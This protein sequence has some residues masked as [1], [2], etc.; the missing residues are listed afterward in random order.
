MNLSVIERMAADGDMSADAFQYLLRCHGECEWLDYKEILMLEHDKQLCDFAKDIV[1]IKNTGGGYVLVG[2]RDKTWEPVG[3]TSPLPFDTKMI[4][5]QIRKATGLDLDVDIVHHKTQLT[6]STGLF[7]LILIRSSRKRRRRRSPSLI[8]KDFCVNKDFGLRRGDIYVRRGD[9]TI[10]IST[11]KELE[12]LLDQLEENA[13]Q[14]ALSLVGRG[15]PFAVHNGTYLL[16]EKGFEQFI[17]R[18]TLRSGLLDA[19][20]KDPRI[21]I[22]NV[23]GPGGAGK[24]ALVNW[25]VYEFFQNRQFEAI[26]QLTAKDTVLTTQGIEKYGRTLYSLEN[27]LDHV[28]M[29]FDETLPS[30]L[31]EKKRIV[32]EY[33]SA[34][35][36]LLV[37]DNMETVQDGRILNFVQSLPPE[38]KAKVLMTSRQKT[39]GWELPFPVNELNVKEVQDFVTIRSSEMGISFPNDLDTSEK[40]WNATGGLPLAI[41]WVLGRYKTKPSLEEITIGVKTKDSPVLEFSFRNI[42]KVLSP[43]AKALLAII[44][45]FD[46]PPTVQSICI[47]TQFP[48]EKVEKAL[49]E[50]DEVTLVNK[51]TSAVDGRVTFVA[52]P[53][54]LAFARNQLAEMDDFEVQCRQRFQKYSEQI[55]LQ[56]SEIFRFRSRFQQFGLETDNEKKAAILCQRGESEMFIGNVNNAD[57][58]F[59]QA[60][61]TAPQSSYVYAMSA[62]YELARNRVGNAISFTEKACSCATK[63]TGALCYTIKARVLDVQRDR[64]GRVEALKKALEYASDD[65]VLR[66]QYGVALSRAGDPVGAIKEFDTIIDAE[67][68]KPAPSLQTIVAMKTRM[69]NLKRLNRMEDCRKDLEKVKELF[70][71]YPYLSSEAYQFNEFFEGEDICAE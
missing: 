21:W 24:T 51:V 14:D 4:R 26:I 53:I 44:T 69:I 3:L 11:Q 71:N 60:R 56:E 33:L 30:D 5:D 32:I 38:T 22:I 67:K 43:D 15:S 39:G 66:H 35:R 27:L 70:K 37:L 47:A 19:V 18:D 49:G 65:A 9:S 40:I 58:L 54:T 63:K 13:D 29:A 23:H 36:T 16:L 61:D 10:R 20:I 17:G 45:I 31:E 50:L 59:K 57:M 62:S 12:D 28:L 55:S 46:E 8:A 42:W 2:V 25:V 52:L 68:A 34:W 7:A 41:Q 1:A 64:N 6:S 48:P